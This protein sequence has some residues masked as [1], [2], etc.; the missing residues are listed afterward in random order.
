MAEI[1]STRIHDGEIAIR[2]YMALLLDLQEYDQIF[3]YKGS[4]GIS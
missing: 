3:F 4:L 1:S 2:V